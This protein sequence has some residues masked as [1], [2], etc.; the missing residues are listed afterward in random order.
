MWYTLG[1]RSQESNNSSTLNAP[2]Q[3]NICGTYG[4]WSAAHLQGLLRV[5]NRYLYKIINSMVPLFTCERCYHLY[6]LMSM[7]YR[8]TLYLLINEAILT[9]GKFWFTRYMYF[10]TIFVCEPLTSENGEIVLSLLLI[11]SYSH[12]FFVYLLNQ[13]IET[14]RCQLVKWYRLVSGNRWS[15]DSD[16]FGSVSVYQRMNMVCTDTL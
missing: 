11:Y 1:R 2:E 3:E 5:F 16:K 9:C 13:S 8:V 15:F 12:S 14:N 6:L 7:Q 10:H 4:P